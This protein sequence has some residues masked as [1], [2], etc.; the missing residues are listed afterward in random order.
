[1]MV[2][3]FVKYFIIKEKNSINQLM[4]K[5]KKTKKENGVCQDCSVFIFGCLEC[6]PIF[7][8][9]IFQNCSK[10]IEGYYLSNTDSERMV[11]KKCL[12][13]GLQIKY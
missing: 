12:Y 1:M 5:K 8:K 6:H 7:I 2:I 4:I 3:E 10:C 13:R 11:C 9:S